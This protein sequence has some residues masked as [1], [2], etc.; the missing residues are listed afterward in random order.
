MHK[1][2]VFTQLGPREDRDARRWVLDTGATN[3]MIEARSAFSEL[4]VSV[5]GSVKFG[6]GFVVE[7]EGRGTIVFHYKNGSI[8]R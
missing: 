7:I 4:D 6:D 8:E 3:Y 1:A 5:C 2:K